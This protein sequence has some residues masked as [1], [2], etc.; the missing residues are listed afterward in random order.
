M[1]TRIFSNSLKKS[2]G[3]INVMEEIHLGGKAGV[4]EG[5]PMQ[6]GTIHPAFGKFL[7]LFLTCQVYCTQYSMYEI[8]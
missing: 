8:S 2:K 7:S 1:D 5:S 3:P 6:W 4:K